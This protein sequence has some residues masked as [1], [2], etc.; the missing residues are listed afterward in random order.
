MGSV[1]AKAFAGGFLGKLAGTLFIAICLFLGFGPDKWAK[2]IVSEFPTWVTP[3]LAQAAFLTLAAITFIALFLPLWKWKQP[4]AVVAAGASSFSGAQ[5]V[6]ISP[7]DLYIQTGIGADYDRRTPSRFGGVLHI[8]RAK[9]INATGIALSQA[10]VS[11]VN[12]NPA[13]AGHRD[14]PLERG[15]TLAAG[16]STYV[17]VAS[18]QE[19]SEANKDLMCLQ[20]SYPGG[21]ITPAGYGILIGEHRLQLRLT[22]DKTILAEI[23]CRLY[24][25]DHDVMR[26]ERLDK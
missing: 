5:A 17:N 10:R 22:R 12:L 9:I 20:T 24:I 15:I 2:F 19:G 21:F 4:D 8:I 1:F 11:I 25:D 13:N 7:T 18:H 3:G 14:F 26:L 23:F 6:A 16:D